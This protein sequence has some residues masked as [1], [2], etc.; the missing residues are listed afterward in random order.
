M[1]NTPFVHCKKA[2]SPCFVFS[3]SVG[4]GEWDQQVVLCPGGEK[5]T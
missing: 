2:M 1:Q 5:T 4:A 3:L